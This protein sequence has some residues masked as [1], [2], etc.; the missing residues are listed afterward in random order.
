MP[1]LNFPLAVYSPWLGLPGMNYVRPHLDSILPGRT[2]ALS[3]VAL[4][5]DSAA[6]ST[7]C[8]TLY[9][10]PRLSLDD[11]EFD[12]RVPVYDTLPVDHYRRFTDRAHV[13]SV[14]RFLR[15]HGVNVLLTQ[16]MHISLPL[17]DIA[18]ELGIRYFVQVHGTDI[19]SALLDFEVRRA[20]SRYNDA[21]GIFSP[22]EFGRRQLFDLGLRAPVHVVRHGVAVPATP[23][24]KRSAALRCA[25]VGRMESLKDPLGIIDIFASVS[26]ACPRAR[27]DYIG[28]G[29]MMPAV[30]QRIRQ[31]GLESQVTL[32]GFAS[33]DTVERLLACSHV[34]LHPSRLVPRDMRFDTCPVAVAEA[35]AQGVVVVATR[36]GGIP[37][38]IRDGVDGFLCEEAD[39]ASMTA[40]VVEL[41]QD[42]A[43]RRRVSLA[44]W[45]TARR[46]FSVDR[47]RARLLNLLSLED[48]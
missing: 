43:M 38:E 39:Y 18:R 26:H 28:S 30:R 8:P 31:L 46:R 1:E 42:A 36:H 29:T 16:W 33:H 48:D 4:R 41:W 14:N 23:P 35:M 9:V 25:A 15:E 44:A 10:P 40:R 24:A 45:N 37:E 19:S 34:L 3:I 5:A 6:W 22:S 47:M 2:V 27:L 17:L 32:H 21:D 7:T 11:V 12:S 13:D 20:F